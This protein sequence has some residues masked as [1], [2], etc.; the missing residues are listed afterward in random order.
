LL[1]RLDDKVALR[2]A[3]IPFLLAGAISSLRRQTSVVVVRKEDKDVDSMMVESIRSDNSYQC[4]EN[5]H[6]VDLRDILVVDFDD[7]AS[8]GQQMKSFPRLKFIG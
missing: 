4:R 2:D 8:F 3:K 1:G 6:R 5:V 7:L